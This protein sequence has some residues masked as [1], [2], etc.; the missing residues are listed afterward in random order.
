M[1]FRKDTALVIVKLLGEM[2][3]DNNVLHV[4]TGQQKRH[5]GRGDRFT[6]KETLGVWRT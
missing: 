6:F 2:D 1:A 4:A 5:L 3:Q